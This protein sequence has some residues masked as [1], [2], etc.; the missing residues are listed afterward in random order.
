MRFERLDNRLEKINKFLDIYDKVFCFPIEV[1]CKD[2]LNYGMIAFKL[3]ELKEIFLTFIG[4]SL[5]DVDDI[6]FY[7]PGFNNL[8]KVV[9]R[10]RSKIIFRGKKVTFN[11][12]EDKSRICDKR[13]FPFKI[14][15]NFS[16]FILRGRNEIFY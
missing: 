11:H 6:E 9:Q 4:A 5:T 15:F 12:Y 14:S 3:E 8:Y 10:F 13:Y 2:L 1:Q 16:D 7:Y